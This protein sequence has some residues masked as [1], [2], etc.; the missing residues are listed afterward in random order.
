VATRGLQARATSL[1]V[2]SNVLRGVRIQCRPL[3]G[4]QHAVAWGATNRTG[5]GF[6]F[7]LC[8]TACTKGGHVIDSPLLLG[9]LWMNPATAK[10]QDGAVTAALA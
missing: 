3:I 7:D 9:V 5:F 10:I 8:S 1:A 6:Q 2:H 4:R